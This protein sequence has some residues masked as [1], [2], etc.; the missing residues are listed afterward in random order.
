MRLYS[1][2]PKARKYVKESGFLSFSRE[3]WKQFLDTEL[4]SL[5]TASKNVVHKTYE[6]LGNEISGRIIK[7]NDDKI[8]KPNENWRNVEKIIIPQEKKALN[9]LM[10]LL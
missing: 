6:I 8:V 10:Q 9:K 2:E 4:D 5:K 1:I 7:S 3:Y